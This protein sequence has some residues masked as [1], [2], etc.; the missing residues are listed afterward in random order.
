M[1]TFIH[2]SALS[3]DQLWLAIAP[4]L[5]KEG[6]DNELFFFNGFVHFPQV[7][8]R[9]LLVL[10]EVTATRYFRYLP[11][12]LSDPILS[13]Q[14][15]CLRAEC[16]SACNSVYARLDLLKPGFD[17]E[18]GFGTTNV[19]IGVALRTSL[20]KVTLRDNMHLYIGTQ[21]LKAARLRP[22]DEKLIHLKETIHQRP[23]QMPDRWVR[24]LGNAAEIHQKMSPVFHLN[25]V[26]AHMFLSSVPSATGKNQS[27]WLLP[28]NT[29]AKLVPRKSKEAVYISGVH[30][31]SA[32]KRLLTTV[33]GLTFYMPDNHLLGHCL[34]EAQL[35]T[36]R[37][38]LGL[39]PEPWQA[40][41]GEGALLPVLAQQEVLQNAKRLGDEMTF[42]AVINEQELGKKWQLGEQQVIAA[43]GQLA[44]SGILGYDAHAGAY[45]HRELPTEPSRLLKDNPRLAAARKLVDHVIRE[46]EKQWLVDSGGVNYRVTFDST[47]GIEAA[48]CTCAWYF[49][50]Q[51][52]RGPCKHI[53]AVQLKEEEL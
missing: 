24:A 1:R 30:R 39:T 37:L 43:L 2:T 23:V 46:G 53:L 9:G 17:G 26:Q 36:A 22:S 29:G 8:A 49:K 52:G 40:Y 50:H 14:G 20:A 25:R 16:F 51:N 33:E 21:G 32:L 13:A 28:T 31:L 34:V 47:R 15:D 48:V 45:F 27:G 10:A 35:P 6:V 42:Q 7:L 3:E 18:I 44:T 4:A 11:V 38:T 19:D 41:S 12:P 5:T